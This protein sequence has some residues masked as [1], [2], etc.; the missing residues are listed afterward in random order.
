VDRSD[1]ADV[2]VNFD[3]ANP[4]LP[5]G[6]RHDTTVPQQALFLMNSPLVVEQAKRLVALA[7]FDNCQ[8]D[9]ARIRFLYERIYQRSPTDE[10]IALGRDFIANTPSPDELAKEADAMQPVSTDARPFRPKQFAKKQGRKQGGPGFRK[11]APL[12]SWQEYAHALLQANE[13][14]FVN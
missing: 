3:F 11:R 7:E 10:E 13:T 6:R 4:D 12:S 9:A 14:S 5:T 1:V 8:D 2:M